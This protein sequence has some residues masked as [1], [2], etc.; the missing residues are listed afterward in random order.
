MR[1]GETSHL[2]DC[3][4]R[5]R[6]GDQTANQDLLEAVSERLR[7][8]AHVMLRDYPRVKRWEETADVLQN[9]LIRLHRAL[10]TVAPPSPR[11]FFRLATLQIRRELLDLSRHYYGPEG[12]GAHQ[13]SVGRNSGRSSADAP[14]DVSLEPGRLAL[15]SEFH[16]QVELL[17]EEEREVFDL[18][19]YQGLG[20][21]EAAELLGVCAR[22]V[23][24]R[25]QSACLKLHDALQGELPGL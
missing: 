2:R 15:W 7:S 13:K 3:L 9:A 22:T 6:Q 19:W 18:L 10:Q 14:A 16:E 5:L 25:W 11:D 8:L 21:T 24:R 1:A 17:P 4:E 12:V 23:K 20:H